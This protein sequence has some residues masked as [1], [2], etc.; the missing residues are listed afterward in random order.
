VIFLLLQIA[1]EG[2]DGTPSAAEIERFKKELRETH[3]DLTN[4]GGN[5]AWGEAYILEAV[6][7]VYKATRDPW[8][9]DKVVEHVDLVLAKRDDKRGKTDLIRGRVM[10]GWGCENYTDG[11]WHVWLVHSGMITYPIAT[12]CRIINED[13]SLHAKYK[14]KEDEYRAAVIEVVD[15]YDGDWDEKH[16]YYVGRYGEENGTCLAFNQQLALGRT[17][18]QLNAEPYRSRAKRMART[19]KSNLKLGRDETY[20]WYYSPDSSQQEDI[21]HGQ[22]DVDFACL[23]YRNGIEFDKKDLRRFANT[24]IDVCKKPD[25]TF[26]RR[27]DGTG[28]VDADFT[29]MIGG[30]GDL[31]EVHRGVFNVCWTHVVE[32]KNDHYSQLGYAKLLKWKPKE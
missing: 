24:L 5:L 31:A 20:L 23:A 32:K 30:W 16:R 7:D 27:V 9:L 29:Q 4:E 21:S 11:K 6:L 22:I 2:G 3:K 1:F 15:S 8:F 18:I 12:F 25:G 14:L 13:R 19:F 10:P 28:K 26:S 17:L